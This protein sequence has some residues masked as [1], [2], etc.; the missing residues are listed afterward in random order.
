MIL[1]HT[2]TSIAYT[3]GRKTKRKKENA[4]NQN[5]LG[6]ATKKTSGEKKD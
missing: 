2:S 5:K 6:S 1:I 3:E 4:L